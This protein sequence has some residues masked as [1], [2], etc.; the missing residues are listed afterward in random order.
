MSRTEP[1]T[2]PWMRGPIEG[3]SPPVAPVFYCFEQ[4]R[5]DLAK[6]TDGLTREQLWKAFDRA[7]VGFHIRHLGGSVERLSAYLAGKQL[8]EAQLAAL[9]QEWDPNEDLSAL[10]T[11]V[12]AQFAA[13]QEQLRVLDPSTIYDRRTVGRRALPTTV[14]GLIVH[15]CEH[16]QRHLGQA[17][18]LIKL[19][20]AGQ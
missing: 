20:R 8:S 19:L 12:N 18:T 7:S 15:I 9:K 1:Q 3:I 14:I 2:E 5:E 11:K 13:C 6:Y 10:L 16:T 4:V 17:I